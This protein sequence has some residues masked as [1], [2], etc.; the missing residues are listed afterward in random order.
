MKKFSTITGA[1]V[2]QLPENKQDNL[3]QDNTDILR[4]TIDSMIDDYL[5]IEF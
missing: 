5:K 4:C 3:I 1:K 2:G